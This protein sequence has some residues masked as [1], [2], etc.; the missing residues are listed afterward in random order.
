[1]Y[2]INHQTLL[3]NLSKLHNQG[4]QD[5]EGEEDPGITFQIREA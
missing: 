1:M 4:D 2:Q 5:L 3:R